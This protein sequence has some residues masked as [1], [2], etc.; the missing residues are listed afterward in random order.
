MTKE[1]RLHM[2]VDDDLDVNDFLDRL[3][4]IGFVGLIQRIA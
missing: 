2:T 1:Y 3:D 4:K